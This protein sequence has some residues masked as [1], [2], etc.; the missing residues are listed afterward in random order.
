MLRSLIFCLSYIITT[1]SNIYAAKVY[2]NWGNIMEKCKWNKNC[3]ECYIWINFIALWLNENRRSAFFSVATILY[4]CSE[5]T[6]ACT[7]LVFF[8]TDSPEWAKT[9][10]MLYINNWKFKRKKKLECPLTYTLKNAKTSLYHVIF[11][12]RKSIFGTSQCIGGCNYLIN[13][14]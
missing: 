14:F 4:M 7:W 5:P 9:W 3:T 12:K 10:P 13:N 11:I 8:W 1:V 2:Q 6:S